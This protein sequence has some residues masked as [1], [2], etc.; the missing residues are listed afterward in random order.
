[1]KNI[2]RSLAVICLVFL[3][4]CTSR[5]CSSQPVDQQATPYEI[6]GKTYYNTVDQYGNAEHAKVWFGK[7]GSFV[8]TDNT[9][10][11]FYEM[12]G[13]WDIK[14]NVITLTVDKTGIGNFTKVLFEISN[15]DKII[16]KTMLAGSLSDDI[17]TTEKPVWTPSSVSTAAPTPTSKPEPT[18][19]PE[20]GNNN[21]STS[22]DSSDSYIA[23]Y[24]ADQNNPFGN[25]FIEF[26]DD[27][28]F[29]L[30]EVQGMGAVQI[31]GLY[32]QQGNT[33]LFSNFDSEVIDMNNQK[34]YN[35][36]MDIYDEDT[37]ILLKDLIASFKGDVFSITGTKPAGL[38]GSSG[39]G[40][41][42][43][44]GEFTAKHDPSVGVPEQF[45]PSVKFETNGEF[46]F[47]ENCYAGMGQYRGWYE[48]NE[49][50]FI[51][52][53]ED[54]STMQGFAGQDVKKIVFK[55]K[56]ANTIVLSTDLCMS[57]LGDEF[58]LK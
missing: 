37:L 53:V 12:Q 5:G 46:V 47:T 42:Y 40:A 13:T 44:N 8:L 49:I 50:E 17:F 26:H 52:H 4:G 51:L 38:A 33:L 36:E 22:S 25:S 16:L 28:T 34:L 18:K 48:V 45:E 14:E 39:G 58:Y 29:T 9:H 56:D 7:D 32:G 31:N 2:L 19:T 23:Y 11:G 57:L 6:G 35:F 54:A 3:F 10:S 41:M 43:I 30:T 1:M 21:N 15:E 55:K 20:S 27:G 24:N